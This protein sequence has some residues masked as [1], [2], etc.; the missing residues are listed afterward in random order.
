MPKMGKLS[1]APVSGSV[2]LYWAAKPTTTRLVDVPSSVQVP[3]SSAAIFIGIR[4]LDTEIP[5]LRD[6]A[7][8]KGISMA[9]TG[10]SFKNPEMHAVGITS[11][12]WA[13]SSDLGLPIK[14]LS[15]GRS[16][17]VLVIPSDVM[18]STTTVATPVLENPVRACCG[19]MMKNASIAVTPASI[20]T[21]V[22][23]EPLISDARVSA[24]MANAIHASHDSGS[25]ASVPSRVRQMAVISRNSSTPQ[26]SRKK[27]SSF[28]L[29]HCCTV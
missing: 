1:G 9:T 12:S 19:V 14:N 13:S 25:N 5:M 8:T 15:T 16:N 20:D 4:S 29:T 6:H 28:S 24:T 23:N 22:G 10:V 18:N 3:P 21:S 2:T 17:D 26:F 11:R 27:C 7:M